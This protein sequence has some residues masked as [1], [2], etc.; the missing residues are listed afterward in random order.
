MRSVTIAPQPVIAENR[1]FACASKS[2]PFAALSE[3]PSI[4]MDDGLVLP[5]LQLSCLPALPSGLKRV[6]DLPLLVHPFEALQAVERVF[7]ADSELSVMYDYHLYS[8]SGLAYRSGHLCTFSVAMVRGGDGKDSYV[9]EAYRL[10]G[11]HEAFAELYDEI[12]RDMAAEKVIR[13]DAAGPS[14]CVGSGLPSRVGLRCPA[15]PS[16]FLAD[17][18]GTVVY[19]TTVVTAPYSIS[20]VRDCFARFSCD[21]HH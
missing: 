9:L 20:H 18:L 7:Q 14:K 16:N 8:C 17:D 12:R 3:T 21:G 13:D 2:D 4:W 11:S 5:T 10:Q 1:D 15:F 19:G 6:A